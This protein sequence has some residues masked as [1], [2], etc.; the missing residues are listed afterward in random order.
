MIVNNEKVPYV[1][2]TFDV[3][4]RDVGKYELLDAETERE[5]IRKYKVCA[6][7]NKETPKYIYKEYCPECGEPTP[8]GMRNNVHVCKTCDTQYN[9][10]AVP[11]Y[12]PFCGTD[13]DF[14]A[15]DMLV[16]ANLRF[17]VKAATV[18]T[19]S[20]ER[21]LHLISAG[22][23]GLLVALDKF[24]MHLE[25]RF[26]TYAAWWVR[27]EMLDEINASSLVYVPSHRQK[28]YSKA[29]KQ[30][31]FVCRLCGIQVKQSG[32]EPPCPHGEHVFVPL[33][34][35]EQ[36]PTVVSIEKVTICD[37]HQVESITIGAD[38]AKAIRILINKLKINNRD[39]FILLQYYNLPPGARNSVPKSLH[40]LAEITG[41]TP[42]RI[43]QIKERTL[44][45]LRGVLRRN[46]ITALDDFC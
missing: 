5:L 44:K 22:N 9:I 27:K 1:G 10:Y 23:V 28:K 36:L 17:V 24:D 14:V 37:P 30:A 18:F 16:T 26:L 25:H 41:I 12:C 2:R 19:K 40:Q 38:S 43:R 29:M 46:R 15:R 11:A 21:L 32:Y 6:H 7:C 8:K 31:M 3:Y 42:E 13:R 45:D 35:E 39:R 4:Y 34:I 33:K 20:R